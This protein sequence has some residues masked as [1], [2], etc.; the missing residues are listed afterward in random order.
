MNL[1]KRTSVPELSEKILCFITFSR[2]SGPLNSPLVYILY[3]KTPAHEW[4]FCVIRAE[5]GLDY[6]SS[7]TS[8]STGSS[9]SFL[10]FLD[11]PSSLFVV[12]AFVRVV[13]FFGGRFVELSADR[14]DGVG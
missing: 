7:T 2:S 12:L 3:Y 1:P 5:T 10:D 4:G 13:R 8:P 6:F 14:H 9:L 11:L